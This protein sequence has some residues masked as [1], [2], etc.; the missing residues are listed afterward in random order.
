MSPG[1]DVETTN[2]TQSFVT[3]ADPNES[4]VTSVDPTQS[5]VTSAASPS[6]VVNVP[7]VIPTK[8]PGKFLLF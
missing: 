4:S 6:P 1:A 2:S 5:S 3:S 7:T 8:P